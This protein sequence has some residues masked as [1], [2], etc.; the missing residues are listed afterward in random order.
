MSE[1][2]GEVAGSTEVGVPELSLGEV[3]AGLPRRIAVRDDDV[4]TGL[5]QLVLT[6]IELVRQLLEHQAVQRME[7]GS[8]TDE[9]VERLGLAL[10]RLDERLGEIREIFG[11]EPDELNID[12]GPLGRLL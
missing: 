12:L 6:V 8:L 11:L 9:E 5:A 2:R 10:F 4:D 7:G 1:G 3:A